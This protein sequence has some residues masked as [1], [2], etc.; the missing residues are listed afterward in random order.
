[1]SRVRNGHYDVAIIADSRVARWPSVGMT[2]ISSICARMGLTVGMLGGVGDRRD[3]TVLGVIPNATTGGLVIAEDPQGRIHR[4]QARAVVRMTGPA[5][6]PNPFPG[7]REPGLIPYSTA[8]R[9]LKESPL[10]WTPAVGILGAGQKALRLAS[11]LLEEGHTREAYCIEDIRSDSFDAFEVERRRF[12]T[13]GGRLVHGAVLRLSRKAALLWS[14]RIQDALGTRVLDVSRVISVG[15]FGAEESLRESPPG[16]LL[17]EFVQSADATPEDDVLGWATE[18]IR[19]RRLAARLVKALAESTGRAE[20]DQLEKIAS[21]AKKSLKRMEQARQHPTTWSYD[22]KLLRPADRDRVK[23]FVGVPQQA[24]LNR[25]VASLECFDDITCNAC[26]TACPEGAIRIER[27][28]ETQGDVYAVL[29]KSFLIESDCTACGACLKAC[30][31]RTPVLLRENEDGPTSTVTFAWPE[32]DPRGPFAKAETV[33]ILNRRGEALGT[34]RA[35]SAEGGL[36]TVEVPTHMVWDVR[37]LRRKEGLN[38]GVAIAGASLATEARVEV[39]LDGE[40]RLVREGIP[41]TQMLFET[42]RERAGDTLFCPDGACGLCELQVDGNKVLACQSRVHRGMVVK[43]G[44]PMPLQEAGQLLCPCQ[45]L[46]SESVSEELRKGHATT[47]GVAEQTGA[48]AGR[49]HGQLCE[50]AFRRIVA[51]QTSDGESWIDWRFPSRDWVF[52][53]RAPKN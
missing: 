15:P 16:S 18:D 24:H 13:L 27:E 10:K 3:A 35:V 40:R 53:G 19:A 42:G 34:A 47:A 22:G 23:A 17:F 32:G 8:I 44:G 26:Q 46:S 7:W 4:I 37:G 5:E 25:A 1:M 12:E 45:G 30:P 43:T 2:L 39:S 51:G 14:L 11:R 38:D 52:R 31:S 49:C 48:C 36:V 20:R 33:T 21:F 6:M 9:L 28:V 41:V 50:G 29:T